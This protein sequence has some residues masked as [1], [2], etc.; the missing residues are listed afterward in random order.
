[1]HQSSILTRRDD[2]QL[3][4]AKITSDLS[5]FTRTKK[6]ETVLSIIRVSFVPKKKTLPFYSISLVKLLGTN[7]EGG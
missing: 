2:V 1:M 4:E 3:K 6:I 7:Q 5:C